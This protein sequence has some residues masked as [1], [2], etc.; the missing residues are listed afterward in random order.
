[1]RALPPV[2]LKTA[3]FNTGAIE[4]WPARLLR[5]RGNGDARILSR[6]RWVLR[7]KRDGRY[8]A[9][10]LDSGVMPL[11]PSL[12]REPGLEAAMDRLEQIEAAAVPEW[13]AADLPLDGLR[14]RLHALGLDDSYGERTGLD[15]VAEPDTLVFADFDRY[16]RPLWLEV[17]AARAWL[18]MRAAAARDGVVLESISGY[19]SHDYQL[20]I[21]ER[22]LARGQTVEQILTVNA[23]PG[24]SEHHGGCALDIG[25]PGEPPAEETFEGTAAFAWLSEHAGAAGF[26]MSYPRGNPHGIVYEPWHW[27]YAG[28]DG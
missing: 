9:A 11:L 7:R 2:P 5:A 27:R 18:A 4:L 25:T 15:L 1:M 3:L 12:P 6:A 16:R 22:K 24:Y 20:G 28:H 26:V 14:D 13:H 10:V 8:L 23:A 21:F 17:S 19:R